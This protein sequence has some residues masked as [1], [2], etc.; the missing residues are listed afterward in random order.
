ML[1]DGENDDII[2]GLQVNAGKKQAIAGQERSIAQVAIFNGNKSKLE[3]KGKVLCTLNELATR[4]ERVLA[5]NQ[6][7]NLLSNNCQTFC[8]K[9]LAANGLPTYSTDITKT[10]IFL[11][12][13]IAQP[14]IWG[15]II[16][17]IVA[18]I[19]QLAGGS[20]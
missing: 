9:F 17:V 5:S 19:K 7:Y 18:L 12:I 6:Q 3:N 15:F 11:L 20:S 16:T 14:F 8:N 4:A 1:S 10:V 2:L 13:L